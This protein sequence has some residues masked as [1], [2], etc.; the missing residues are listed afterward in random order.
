MILLLLFLYPSGSSLIVLV[1]FSFVNCR[2]ASVYEQTSVFSFQYVYTSLCI[3]KT[4]LLLLIVSAF[5]PLSG[6]LAQ[7]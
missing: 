3:T 5:S 1:L 2:V 6:L 4:F 7:T